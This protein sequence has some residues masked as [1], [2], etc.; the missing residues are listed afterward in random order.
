M[1]FVRGQ[2]VSDTKLIIPVT[3]CI[4]PSRHYDEIKQDNLL[5]HLYGFKKSDSRYFLV[6]CGTFLT[7]GIFR[8]ILHWR[9]AWHIRC[10]ARKCNL[11]DCDYVFVRD[12]HHS[13]VICPVISEN[14]RKLKDCLSK[15]KIIIPVAIG[16]RT[17]EADEFKYF[18]FR[19][20]RLFWHPKYQR[21]ITFNELEKEIFMRDI[22]LHYERLRSGL[23][24]EKVN[25][26]SVVYGTNRL[27]VELTPIFKLLFV[28]VLSP[29]YVFQ[30]FSLI[31]WVY[32]DY[33]YFSAVIFI[34]SLISIVLDLVQIRKQEIK[35]RKMV[36]SADN[37]LQVLRDDKL[38]TMPSEKVVPGDIIQIPSQGCALQ[39][40]AI[41]IRGGTTINE[42]TLTGESTPIHKTAI[43]KFDYSDSANNE[44]FCA[45]QQSKHMLYCGTHVICC[46]SNT[47][48]IVLRT[49]FSTQKGQLIRAIMFPKPV[50]FSFTLDLMKFLGVLSVIALLGFIYSVWM[51]IGHGESVQTIILSALDVITIAVP[52]SLPVVMS[53]G[54]MIAQMR[55][56]R[57]QI[58]CISP[59]TINTCGAVNV[60]C[61]D[62][63]GTLTEDGLDFYCLR[64]AQYR[65]KE[66][67]SVT[68]FGEPI[69][70]IH[71]GTKLA[72]AMA[73]CHSLCWIDGS[74][75]GD[76]M[77]MTLFSK[78]GWDLK[79]EKGRD[80]DSMI[81]FS[82]FMNSTELTVVR[83][84]TFEPALQRM[85]VI[86][87]PKVHSIEQ[88]PLLFCKGSPEMISSLCDQFSIPP[89]FNQYVDDYAERGFRLI[90]VAYRELSPEINVEKLKRDEAEQQ[91]TILGLVV[92]ANRLKT[93]SKE[94]IDE[95]IRAR[96]RT[97]M[98]TGDNLL[99]ATSVGQEC[100]I[101][102]KAWTL[103]R[104]D[105]ESNGAN[106][107]HLVVKE[108]ATHSSEK[109]STS[110]FHNFG[111]ETGNFDLPQQLSMSGTTFSAILKHLPESEVNRLIQK[112]VIYARMAPQQKQ[113]LVNRLKQIGHTVAM[114][115]DGT[116]DS[117]ALKT[118]HVG[119]SLS[120]EAEACIAAPFTSN[121]KDIR[122]VIKVIREGRAALV[123]SFCL[124]K[125]L[126]AYSLIQFISVLILYYFGTT[127]SDF[128]FLYID[129]VLVTIVS[130]FFGY[131]HA[132][133]KLH[134][135]PPPT[136]LLSWNSVVSIIGQLS[137]AFIFQIV[138][139]LYTAKLSW[140]TPFKQFAELKE[141]QKYIG[142][143]GML[144]K[145]KEGTALFLVSTFQYVALVFVNSKGRPHRKALCTNIPLCA[146][147]L[148]VSLASASLILWP[149]PFVVKLFALTSVPYVKDRVI[150]LVFGIA[151]AVVAYIFEVVVVD[152]ILQRTVSKEIHF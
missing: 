109:I 54:I 112:C 132:S 6:W 71:P 148:L 33:Y 72:M 118:A 39:C 13:S 151:S 34:M 58:H 66:T 138:V 107:I 68:E 14:P 18:V 25:E 142:S 89:E 108:V 103:F 101:V 28:E 140:Y 141:N 37:V 5:L 90:A 104:L 152:R 117:A 130:L 60:V 77:D 120:S 134:Q 32:Q 38:H 21:F 74:L 40:D 20:L 100:G 125:Y 110:T 82:P 2:K 48:A 126:A 143:D 59:S 45:E 91:L 42:S 26:R 93:H 96:V 129:L 47:Q 70:S 41:L 119:I 27:D 16:Q 10:I 146:S 80:N 149:P 105:Q 56:K 86:V 115:G 7:F 98:I 106:G 75:S 23:P 53:V 62:K 81:A 69:L 111:I 44:I 57:K 12:E 11:A 97:I 61:F 22:H 145:S 150:Y 63:T 135:I 1:N 17:I 67:N 102:D 131:T 128:Q 137:V 73:T 35:L 99:T 15:A 29:F 36:N 122:C 65:N 87:V 30:A 85:S 79:K 113:I 127:F 83:Q 123:T 4:K 50:D 64:E 19:K 124:F 147:V 136:R 3:N 92:F 144:R 46:A 94:V 55:L 49:G 52:P 88:K 114:C 9:P 121:I 31:L 24:R 139:L 78:S 116:N 51:M 43:S 84:F 133:E 8:L 95:L 76:P